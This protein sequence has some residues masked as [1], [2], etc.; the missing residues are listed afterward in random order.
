MPNSRLIKTY[1][2]MCSRMLIPLIKHNSIETAHLKSLNAGDLIG[3]MK[4]DHPRHMYATTATANA[5][6]PV[7]CPCSSEVYGMVL[8]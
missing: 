1:A 2:D 7:P 6:V 3:P 5:Q 8:A 4:T